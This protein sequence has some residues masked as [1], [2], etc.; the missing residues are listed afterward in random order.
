MIVK[1]VA[2]PNTA[3][4]EAAVVMV[5]TKEIRHKPTDGVE[6]TRLVPDKAAA[7]AVFTDVLRVA[8]NPFFVVAFPA[9]VVATP[10]F[11]T[12]NLLAPPTCKSIR[13]ITGE[14]LPVAV[15]V[16]L[17]S[18]IVAEPVQLTAAPTLIV[19]AILSPLTIADDVLV[20]ANVMP[21]ERSP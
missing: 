14:P 15:N 1:P 3:A 8:L 6:V 11:R 21:N 16:G 20:A 19:G 5:A 2:P 12:V 4:A 17:T 9:T 10:V 18:N 13:L 7:C